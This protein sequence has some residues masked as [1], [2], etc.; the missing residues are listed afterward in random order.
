[1]FAINAQQRRRD[2]ATALFTAVHPARGGPL[3]RGEALDYVRRTLDATFEQD[4]PKIFSVSARQ[5]LEAKQAHDSRCHRL[6]LAI[7]Y[8]RCVTATVESPKRILALEM[9]TPADEKR[10]L[11]ANRS[12][13]WDC[14]GQ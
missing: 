7:D 6:Q 9:T 3:Q 5:T 2:Q 11:P 4:A 13:F 12:C 8:D 10:E 14:R 1:V